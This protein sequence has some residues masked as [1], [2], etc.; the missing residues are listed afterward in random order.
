ME[1][2]EDG[3]IIKE[4]M[5]GIL[6]LALHGLS[7]KVQWLSEMLKTAL[8]RGLQRYEDELTNMRREQE[9][10][11]L[12]TCV[13]DEKRRCSRVDKLSQETYGNMMKEIQLVIGQMMLILQYVSIEVPCKKFN[14]I[15]KGTLSYVIVQYIMILRHDL[16]EHIWERVDFRIELAI[17][18]MLHFSS[19]AYKHFIVN[20]NIYNMNKTL[21]ELHGMLGW[22]EA[23][24]D[25]T[26]RMNVKL[27]FLDIN[28]MPEDHNPTSNLAKENFKNSSQKGIL[29]HQIFNQ[30]CE[31]IFGALSAKIDKNRHTTVIE[32]LNQQFGAICFWVGISSN[33]TSSTPSSPVFG[34]PISGPISTFTSRSMNHRYQETA[35]ITRRAHPTK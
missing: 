20:F 31:D 29:N 17:D 35:Q 23:S 2:E 7:M 25:K 34:Q 32:G 26:H 11:Y 5:A 13:F 22:T 30:C 8:D 4:L 1:I 21:M 12:F 10:S 27:E 24:M 16:M 33:G 28:S 19:G 15:L 6:F 3:L 9:A 14:I 18:I